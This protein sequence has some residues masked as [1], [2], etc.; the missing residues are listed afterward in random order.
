MLNVFTTFTL[1]YHN[2]LSHTHHLKIYCYKLW[3][4]LWICE[5]MTRAISMFNRLPGGNNRLLLPGR[6]QQYNRPSSHSHL[7]ICYECSKLSMTERINE[8]SNFT[9]LIPHKYPQKSRWHFPQHSTA[10]PEP[11]GFFQLGLGQNPPQS[12]TQVELLVTSLLSQFYSFC[13]QFSWICRVKSVVIVVIL[14]NICIMQHNT[15]LCV[16]QLISVIM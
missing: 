14:C 8:A 15:H 4:K 2:R 7:W 6:R 11:G 5:Q 10:P 9:L 3:V 12:S 16:F 13:F 1:N